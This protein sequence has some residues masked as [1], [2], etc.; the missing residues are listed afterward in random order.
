M[1]FLRAMLRPLL[2]SAGCLIL[3]AGRNAALGSP[4]I[5]T[6]HQGA[7]VPLSVCADG[8]GALLEF[9][10]NCI[11]SVFG[12]CLVAARLTGI[13]AGQVRAVPGC[14]G[15]A[16]L[17]WVGVRPSFGLPVAGSASPQDLGGRDMQ[18]PP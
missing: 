9:A 17:P 3:L 5:V 11:A 18:T 8:F 14:H 12:C 6:R 15:P 16:E 4:V 1:G 10:L 13:L 2:L 7:S